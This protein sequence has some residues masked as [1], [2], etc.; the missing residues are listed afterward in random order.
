YA[1][2]Y[3]VVV[4]QDNLEKRLQ[5]LRSLYPNL[6]LEQTIAPSL[7]DQVLHHFN[8]RVHKDEHVRIYQ[9]L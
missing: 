8:P 7:Y 6:K 3:V 1:P 2:N 4:G 5:R 9:I